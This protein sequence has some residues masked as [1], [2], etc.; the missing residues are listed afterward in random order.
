ML[1]EV[2]TEFIDY[3]YLNGPW[4]LASD[5]IDNSFLFTEPTDIYNPDI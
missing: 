2:G 5:Q 1:I 3:V 4:D